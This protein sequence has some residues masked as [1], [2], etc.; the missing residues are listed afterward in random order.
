MIGAFAPRGFQARLLLAFAGLLTVAVTGAGLAVGV[1]S[2]Q[3]VREQMQQKALVGA[4]VL[5]SHLQARREQLASAVNVLTNDFGFKSAVATRDTATVASTLANHGSRIGADLMVLLTGDGGAVGRNGPLADAAVPF[6]ADVDRARA[7]G[8][9]QAVGAHDG[10]LYQYFVV[11]VLAPTPIAWVVV[12]F[13]IDAAFA[14]EIAQ[15]T[16]LTIGFV[17]VETTGHVA[18]S[19]GIQDGG[20]LETL[21]NEVAGRDLQ[22]HTVG[23]THDGDFLTA[24]AL[25]DAHADQRA[26][27]VLQIPTRT[28]SETVRWQL[29]QIA[30][31]LA[32]A[33]G[34]TLLA[35]VWLA[36]RISR[37]VRQLIDAA[38][39]IERGDYDTPVAADTDGEM[40]LLGSAL[41]TMRNAVREREARIRHQADHDPLTDLPNLRCLER[42]A[43]DDGRPFTLCLVGL[44]D[45]KDVSFSL[46]HETADAL[47][48]AVAERLRAEPDV[49]TVARV[50]GNEFA[51]L[52]P[53]WSSDRALHRARQINVAVSQAHAVNGRTVATRSACAV[54]GFPGDADCFETLFRRV[55][56]TLTTARQ[57]PDRC[58][59]YL[60]GHEAARERRLRIIAGF[61]DAFAYGQFHLQFQP[62][63]TLPGLE[64]RECEA[65]LRWRHP[66]LGAVPPDE[67]V[68]LAERS[69]NIRRLSDWVLDHAVAQAG[70]W[71]RSGLEMIVAVN[72]SAH[73]IAEPRLDQVVTETLRRHD[74]DGSRIILEI[75]ESAVMHDRDQA[76]QTLRRLK[77]LGIRLSIDDFGTGHSSLA[78]LKA[79]PVDELKI[80]KSFVLNLD[81]H[82][83][84]ALIVRSTIELGHNLG[85]RVVAEG[86]ENAASLAL[87]RDYGCDKVQGYHFARPMDA[88]AFERWARDHQRGLEPLR[89]ANA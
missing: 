89:E 88:D 35:G 46:G 8:R 54:I 51:V 70:A 36:R 19:V 25:L 37:P 32:L 33:L 57:Q 60:P 50:A 66:E 63:V 4:R 16:D 73:D 79:L 72:L 86:L 42:L 30:L 6:R 59:A 47:L 24:M 84:D 48:I 34:A 38:R 20:H 18:A 7:G 27:A 68:Q 77:A 64:A 81:R 44:L 29:L 14:A 10:K 83:D 82:L 26:L 52:L 87:L 39:G 41:N 23:T 9:V 49:R 58:A 76:A 67:F 17:A 3:Q 2:T 65:L 61:D 56:T 78:Q 85:L 13:A 75:T 80:D 31:V 45:L 74:V 28:I 1:S 71:Q 11:P 55:E 40:A 53:A 15:L 62:K 22:G 12:G 5:E 21:M 43:A 69:G